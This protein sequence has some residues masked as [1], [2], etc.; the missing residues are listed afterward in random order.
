MGLVVRSPLGPRHQLF[1]RYEGENEA[2][3]EARLRPRPGGLDMDVC[4]LGLRTIAH[5]QFRLCLLPHL[6]LLWLTNHSVL[7]AAPVQ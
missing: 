1:P 4:P 2:G 6:Q 3:T 5:V 7:P